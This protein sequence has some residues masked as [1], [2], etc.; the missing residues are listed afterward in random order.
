MH[1]HCYSGLFDDLDEMYQFQAA[2]RRIGGM[3]KPTSR[4]TS[5]GVLRA[6]KA[7]GEHIYLCTLTS[8]ETTETLTVAFHMRKPA[9]ATV[10]G[11][12]RVAE[13]AAA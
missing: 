4:T 1:V 7:S 10:E 3:D 8:A 5:A 13:W 12:H 9:H 6:A 2:L 11:M